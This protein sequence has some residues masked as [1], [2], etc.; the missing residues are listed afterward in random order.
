MVFFFFIIEKLRNECSDFVNTYG[1]V[2]AELIAGA[3]DPN[4]ICHYIGV[5]QASSST[6]SPIVQTPYTCL[7]CQYINNR[8]KLFT[9]LKHK[10]NSILPAVKDS[11]NLYNVVSLQEECKV[12][13]DHY[14]TYF[15][16]KIFYNME[17][18]NACQNIGIC[19]DNHL[20]TTPTPIATSTEYAK[21]IFGMN[22]WC[23]S[24]AN[25]ELCNVRKRI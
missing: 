23:T 8:I 3:A 13:L 10:Q 12:F 22:Y 21:C 25:A 15:S 16:Q 11:C 7:I 17:T 5:C 4:T 14:G 24:H 18:R 20:S 19:T 6:P 2:I 1:P 9:D